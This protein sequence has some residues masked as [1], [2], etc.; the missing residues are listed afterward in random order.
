MSTSPPTVYRRGDRTPR[1]R[2]EDISSNPYERFH[3]F[4]NDE[5]SGFKSSHMGLDLP[6]ER[7]INRTTPIETIEWLMPGWRVLTR[8]RT[9][10]TA[11]WRDTGDTYW[12]LTGRSEPKPQRADRDHLLL[13]RDIDLTD[14]GRLTVP[15]HVLGQT[16]ANWLLFSVPITNAPPFFRSYGRSPITSGH[17]WRDW[18]P[19]E[20]LW[21]ITF[22]LRTA[23][24]GGTPMDLVN[25]LCGLH[26]DPPSDPKFWPESDQA[27]T[28]AAALDGQ[29]GS[30]THYSGASRKAALAT[31]AAPLAAV[32]AL[33]LL[34]GLREWDAVVDHVTS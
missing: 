17:L 7:H 3:L 16:V 25:S 29:T 12:S 10:Q 4:W 24:I 31:H 20:R 11:T 26:E 13:A 34:G 27:R 23:I 5:V 28:L 33:S 14:G 8:L 18:M 22:A 19:W 2:F 9:T 6:E 32:R 30:G 15:E 21:V 1:R